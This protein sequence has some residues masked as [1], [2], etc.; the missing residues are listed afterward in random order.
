ML[1]SNDGAGSPSLTIWTDRYCPGI[2]YCTPLHDMYIQ[3]VRNKHET[4][5]AFVHPT[6]DWSRFVIV[7]ASWRLTVTF[8]AL[9]AVAAVGA[10]GLRPRGPHLHAGPPIL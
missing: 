6:M 2:P 4:F 7:H 5:L 8:E 1:R 9:A 10:R 3:P